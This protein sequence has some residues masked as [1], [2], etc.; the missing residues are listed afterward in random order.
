MACI[1]HFHHFAKFNFSSRNCHIYFLQQ[2]HVNKQICMR[3]Q[4]KCDILN[5]RLNDANRNELG[6]N[7]SQ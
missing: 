2:K 1:E 7:S 5:K 3:I 6:K 4:Q